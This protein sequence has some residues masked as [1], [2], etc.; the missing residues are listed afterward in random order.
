MTPAEKEEI[1]ARVNL[2]RSQGVHLDPRQAET[3]V[4]KVLTPLLREERYQ[5][6]ATS[7]SA[8]L[9]VDFLAKR[10]SAGADQEGWS[11][12]VQFKHYRNRS[13]GIEPV[14]AFAGTAL[15]R[16]MTRAILLSTSTFSRAAHEFVRQALPL[17][18]EL[19]DLD[20]LQAWI[21]R[22]DVDQH[23]IGIEVAAILRAT[24]HH[25][26]TMIAR[27]QRALDH[28]EWRDMERTIAEVFDGLGFIAKLTPPSKD[29]GKDVILECTVGDDTPST[30]S[31]SSIGVQGASSAGRP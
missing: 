31:K 14:R 28:I 2:L 24:G 23:T 21:A 4:M 20:G 11:L 16:G 26:A 12:G 29:G 9:G 22:L 3:L 27:D 8:D 6:T 1:A 5:L 13:V 25:F 30:L 17:Q 10:L 15:T 19:M 7:S 18:I